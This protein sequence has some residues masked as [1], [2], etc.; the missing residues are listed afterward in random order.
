MV[1]FAIIPALDAGASSDS[2][3]K[4][5]P[6]WKDLVDI[7]V[8]HVDSGPVDKSGVGLRVS[9]YVSEI[10]YSMVLEVIQLGPSEDI[11]AKI[12]ERYNY[13]GFN[14]GN[15]INLGSLVNTKLVKWMRWN[16]FQLIEQGRL[17]TI[18]FHSGGEIEISLTK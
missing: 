12:V 10:Y 1:I 5:T 15:K 16:K 18:E 11:P 7:S 14:I 8:V 9:F 2:H 3:L 6:P 17:F 13:S 4:G